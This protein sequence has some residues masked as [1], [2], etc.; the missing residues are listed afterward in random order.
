MIRT[1]ASKTDIDNVTY[2]SATDSN[3]FFYDDNRNNSKAQQI[4]L[5]RGL[6]NTNYSIHNDNIEEKDIKLENDTLIPEQP[7]IPL[8]TYKEAY[9]YFLKNIPNIS[10]KPI[11][12]NSNNDNCCSCLGGKLA[13]NL[14]IEKY[15]LLNLS[16][17]KYDMNNDIHFRIL[18]TIYYFFTKKNCSK[19]GEHWQDIGLQSDDVG[20]DLLTVGMLGPLQM[21][22]AID[23]YPKFLYNLYQYL[24]LR[25]CELYFGTDMINFTKFTLNMM[26]R[27]IL[28]Y[29]FNEYKQ[30]TNIT[31]EIYVGMAYYFSYEIQQYGNQ[32][33]L[34]IEFIVKTIQ[35]ISEMK[36]QPNSFIKN[37]NKEV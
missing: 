3:M 29:N 9:N 2:S 31:N 35:K 16:K 27:G 28:D 25:Q 10:A 15:I 5:R 14:K 37:H 12:L 30:V 11:K 17:V 34:T 1:N 32:N 24:A 21:L 7:K 22:Y 18:F 26:E 19:V 36:N 23:E 20:T 33:D 6:L 4:K 8:I 13:A